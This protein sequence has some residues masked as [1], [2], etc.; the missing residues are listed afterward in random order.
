[1]GPLPGP[2]AS[3]RIFS[4]H[5]TSYEVRRIAC[6]DLIVGY[7]PDYD[8]S[9]SSDGAFAEMGAWR[10]DALGTYPG[11]LAK[12]DRSD[13]ETKGRVTP[14]MVSGAKVSTLRDTDV[15]TNSNGREIVNPGA[16]T[17]PAMV[18]HD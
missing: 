4:Y 2:F 7:A 15:R 17:N 9:G 3:P 5:T 10:E 8:S 13:Q 1:M 12:F 14:I 11:T 18:P 6:I 16:F